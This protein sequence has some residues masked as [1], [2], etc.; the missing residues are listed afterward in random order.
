VVFVRQEQVADKIFDNEF[1]I[2]NYRNEQRK[3][4]YTD[5]SYVNAGLAPSK[6]LHDT[7]IKTAKE[8]FDKGLT[9]G[10]KRPNGKGKRIIMIHIGSDEG[11]VEDAELVWIGGKNGKKSEDYHDD[12]DST[13]FE[14]WLQRVLPKLPPGSVVI[15]DNASYHT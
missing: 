8:A 1:L 13:K 4:F 3:I 9:T 11:F 2:L 7:S 5:E 10:M 15:M 12:M 14:A 6:I